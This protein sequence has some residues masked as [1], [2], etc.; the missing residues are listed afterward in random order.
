MVVSKPMRKLLHN[1]RV[2][3][4]RTRLRVCSGAASVGHM[5]QLL[6]QNFQQEAQLLLW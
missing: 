6:T 4:R 3:V 2:D 5:K 1:H